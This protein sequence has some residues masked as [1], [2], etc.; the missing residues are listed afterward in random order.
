[1]KRKYKAQAFV[2]GSSCSTCAV[3]PCVRDSRETLA[4]I[5]YCYHYKREEAGDE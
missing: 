2:A 1:M 3:W 5:V 4:V